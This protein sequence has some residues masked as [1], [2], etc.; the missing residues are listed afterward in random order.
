MSLPSKV[1]CLNGHVD[2]ITSL[3]RRYRVISRA[4]LVGS[5]WLIAPVGPLRRRL[6]SRGNIGE[7]LWK[8]CAVH[9]GGET[10]CALCRADWHL[11]RVEIVLLSVLFFSVPLSSFF[12][13][14]SSPSV[15]YLRQEQWG[16]AP[17]ARSLGEGDFW[18]FGGKISR[19][20]E[21][22]TDE[23]AIR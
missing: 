16:G 8:R 5:D 22:G 19:T 2:I 12:T 23:G 17:S 21:V 20:L 1:T 6:R 13:L 10:S 11:S 18:G 14:L 3:M 15:R 7:T 4:N 9:L